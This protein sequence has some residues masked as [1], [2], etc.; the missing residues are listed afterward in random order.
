MS[1]EKAISP[2]LKAAAQALASAKTGRVEAWPMF[3]RDAS[4]VLAAVDYDELRAYAAELSERLDDLEGMVGTVE[5]LQAVEEAAVEL[6]EYLM[7]NH[8]CQACEY[9][10]EFDMGDWCIQTRR[11]NA[12]VAAIQAREEHQP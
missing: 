1:E 5:Q 11:M 6:V 2:E 12:V 3:L 10:Q 7:V 4:D 9:K 8:W